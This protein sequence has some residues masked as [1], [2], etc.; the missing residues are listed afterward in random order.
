MTATMPE[1]GQLFTPTAQLVLPADAS[2]EEW[3][4]ARRRGIGGSDALAV[5]GLSPYG[6]R[7]SVWAEKRGLLRPKDDNEA[8]YWGRKLEPILAEEFTERTGIPTQTCGLLQHVERAWQLASV[9]RLSA[10]DGIVEIKTTSAYKAADWDEE[11]VADA[12]EAQLQHYFAVT[13]K[14]HGYAVVLIGGQ[15]LEI[16]HVHR[17][18]RLIKVMVEAEAELWQM[19]LDGTAPA[20]DGSAASLRALNEL[21]PTAGGRKVALDAQTVA[22]LRRYAGWA[23]EATALKKA[24]DA[25]KADVCGELKDATV[26]TWIGQDVVTWKNTGDFNAEAFTAAHP[27]VAAACQKTV[28]DEKAVKTLHPDLYAAYRGR[29]FH[30]VKKGLAA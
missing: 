2:R 26:G 4:A 10:D 30:V 20:M 25:A 22:T 7:Y 29:R 27:D 15:R 13:G 8:M 5:L 18:E 3:L 6:S 14:E 1:T 17:D 23:E 9:D 21:Y 16:R 28:L 19:V 12:A 24:K 11:Q